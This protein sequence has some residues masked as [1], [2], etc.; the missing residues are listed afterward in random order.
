MRKAGKGGRLRPKLAAAIE[1]SDISTGTVPVNPPY[2]DYLAHLG[3]QW[4]M[5][6]NDV[7]SDCV[8]VTWSNYRRLVTATLGPV[9][10]YPPIAQV[11]Q[12]YRTQNPDFDPNGTAVTNGPGSEADGG[13]DIQT[14]LEELHAN[15]GPDGVKA[16]AFASVNLRNVSEVKT[17]IGACG[18]LWTGINVYSNNETEFSNEQPFDYVAGAQSLGGHSVLTGGYGNIA[19]DTEQLGGDEKFITWAEETS[20]TDR[21]WTADVEEGWV[22]IWPEQLGTRSFEQG[23]DQA[24]LV[25]AYKQATGRRLV[26]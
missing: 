26:L 15:G 6:G 14:G 12:F 10:V 7:A 3:G 13:M 23:I 8:A 19:V 18:A 16:V 21:Y 1:F 17:A 5:L 22:V 20:F 9:A 24:K 4:E 2:V 25:A 11:W